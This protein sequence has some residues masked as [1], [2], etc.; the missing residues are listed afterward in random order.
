M[1]LIVL[2]F[3]IHVFISTVIERKILV[4]VFSAVP[5]PFGITY[6]VDAAG[7][8]LG[9][10][11]AFIFAVV[12]PT[13]TYFVEEKRLP[14]FS[15]LMFALQAALLGLSY[16]G[17]VFNIF[18]MLEL[19]S[20]AGY[21]LIAFPLTRKSL[22]AALRY[23]VLGYSSGVV[24]FIAAVMFYNALGTL[25]IGHAALM[26]SG[27]E[28]V[29]GRS[30][31]AYTSVRFML[32]IML[33]SL[34]VESAIAPLHFWLPEAYAYT[35]PSTAA[36]MAAVAEGISIY[37]IA[38]LYY[39]TL[40]DLSIEANYTML[41]L[42][43]ITIIVGAFGML[44]S[45]DVSKVIAYSTVMDMGYAG[46]ALTL[47][48]SGLSAMM[49]YILAHSVIKPSLFLVT[50]WIEKN[51]GGTTFSKVAGALRI[52]SVLA[53]S[54]ILSFVSLVGIPPT[55]MFWAKYSLYTAAI[56]AYSASGNIAYIVLLIVMM[57]GS[58]VAFAAM[59]RTLYPLYFVPMSAEQKDSMKVKLRPAPTALGVLVLSFSLASL[60]LGL[61]IGLIQPY[62]STAPASSLT[63][64]REAYMNS[65]EH[66]VSIVKG[67][68]NS[69]VKSG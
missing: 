55:I 51:V 15:A 56:E 10:L 32:F 20:T 44:F 63:F 45:D 17:D 62:V 66:V 27:I 23:A 6:V 64:G 19:A 35:V 37:L 36:Y 2:A 29:L 33:W 50:G 41:L 8:F 65:V 69:F 54:F 14:Y 26:V 16:T 57:L 68:L 67:I 25:N 4:Y 24:F 22:R 40:G 11:A 52:D 5:P 58:A 53:L 7:G 21:A 47:G 31:S 12:L 46:S 28:P 61:A 48:F 13:A 60:I 49:I 1:Q 30:A 3:S 9:L 59:I 34:L 43:M 39:T 42:S 18:V 38:R